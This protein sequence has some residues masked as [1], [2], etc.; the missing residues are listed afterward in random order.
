[1]VEDLRSVS[2]L[3]VLQSLN[4]A[5]HYDKNKREESDLVL[6]IGPEALYYVD[7][8]RWATCDL[9]ELLK[10]SKYREAAEVSQLR[11]ERLISDLNKYSL[12]S[13]PQLELHLG[14]YFS[15]QLWVIIAQIH[16]NF[17]AIKVLA[18]AFPH[19]NLL[20]YT[21]KFSK[22]FMDFRPDPDSIFADVLLRSGIF[23]DEG[24]EVQ[25]VDGEKKSVG[26][27]QTFISL[28]PRFFQ[29]TLRDLR[30]KWQT[31]NF[32]CPSIRL[33]LIGGGYDWLKIVRN[34]CFSEKF[35]IDTL[36]LKKISYSRRVPSDLIVI[37]NESI[38]EEGRVVYELDDLA[39][40]IYSHMITF[41]AIDDKVRKKLSRFHAVVTSVLS[42]PLDLYLGHVAAKLN[43][44][45]I[46][47]QHG[48]KGQN[49][50]PTA[51]YTELCYATSYWAYGCKVADQY[52]QSIGQNRLLNVEVIGSLGKAVSW[53]GGK[54]IVYATGKW[55]KTSS[56]LM[57]PPNPDQRLFVAHKT[58]LS[59]L[60]SEALDSTVIFKANNT[61]GL[62]SVP[63]KYEN[64]LIDHDT[65][66]SV[67]LENSKLVILDTPATTLVEACSTKVPIFVLGGR[68][69]YCA[70]FLE[71]V[72]R[73]VVWCETSSGL[74]DKV[75]K[76]LDTGVY[77]A[78]VNDD[79]YL[80]AYGASMSA[81]EV[82]AN[83]TQNLIGA[84]EPHRRGLG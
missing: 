62:N 83:V 75:R 25:R 73:R 12:K 84:I 74:V 8:R 23:C 39:R 64:I 15:F 56:S 14:S 11:I 80:R 7:L 78:D 47:W 68:M 2:R 69:D 4:Q 49:S 79:S 63:Y 77:D 52:R 59:Y 45:L 42:Q 61:R 81:S 31:R 38:S 9:N 26:F 76:F 55:F 22:P 32:G 5:I 19:V 20:V 37:L 48:E 71:L 54:T 51:V 34:K 66:F 50:D 57:L 18:I 30:L 1:M 29:K 70:D 72:K 36:S 28:L 21:Q 10:R 53:Y 13:I 43:M 44:P 3:V 41:A 17:F 6:A 58:I 33:L 65:S 16:Y 46:V 60:N 67:L 27:K 35:E 82:I 40:S 24:I